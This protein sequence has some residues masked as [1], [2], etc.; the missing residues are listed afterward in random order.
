VGDGLPDGVVHQNGAAGDSLMELRRNIA[1][2]LFHPRGVLRPRFEEGREVGLRH[3]KNVDEDNWRQIGMQL[4]K[5]G[6]VGVERL[7]LQQKGPPGAN[8]S[9][10]ENDTIVS[11]CH[12]DV[13]LELGTGEIANR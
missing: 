4:L 10:S 6:H 1:G 5:D 3:L 7:Q 9:A 12:Y 13:N 2:L 11:L 8:S